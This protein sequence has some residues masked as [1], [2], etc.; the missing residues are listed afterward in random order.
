MMIPDVKLNQNLVFPPESVSKRHFSFQRSPSP[1]SSHRFPPPSFSCGGCSSWG[2]PSSAPPSA[3]P[4]HCHCCCCLG[5][6]RS[7]QFWTNEWEKTHRKRSKGQKCSSAEQHF[8]CAD[9]CFLGV[10]SHSLSSSWSISGSM[11]SSVLLGNTPTQKETG[12]IVF[13]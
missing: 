9:V 13:F 10:A 2:R 6:Q 7:G 12:K 11:S 3:P 4:L 1:L 8:H 5:W